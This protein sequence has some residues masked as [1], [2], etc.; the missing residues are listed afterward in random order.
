MLDGVD[1]RVD[2]RLDM[3]CRGVRRDPSAG[4]V[5]GLDQAPHV[6]DRVGR[7]RVG[8]RPVRPLHDWKVADDLDPAGAGR[9][10]GQR[11]GDQVL[12]WG[13]LV[14]A[15]VIPVRRCQE[16]SADQQ[17]AAVAGHQLQRDAARAARVADRG[18]PGSPGS[19][20]VGGGGWQAQPDRFAFLVLTDVEVAVGVDEAYQGEPTRQG[21]GVRRWHRGPAAC[22]RDTGFHHVVIRKQDRTQAPGCHSTTVGNGRTV[23]DQQDR[24][25]CWSPSPRASAAPATASD[26]AAICSTSYPH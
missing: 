13:R 23:A 5:N 20:E 3:D 22:R 9:H 12:G 11:G 14:Q 25:P 17:I 6:G 4:G 8:R 18:H 19:G 24:R 16:S 21:F 10:L 7:H 2:Q 1:A 15:R 26:S